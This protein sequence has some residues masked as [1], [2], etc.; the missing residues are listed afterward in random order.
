MDTAGAF[1]FSSD[2]TAPHAA[3]AIFKISYV[4]NNSVSASKL[5]NV[6][7]GI[8]PNPT[9]D[10]IRIEGMLPDIKSIAVMNLLGETVMEQKN[11]HSPDFTLDLSKL[12]P[13]TYYI[14]F[15]SANS[16]VTKMVVRE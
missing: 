1:Y 13:G 9:N 7:F 5:T 14:R 4:G 2:H 10:I 11:L 12:V 3:P 6:K 15:S 16:V 8:Y